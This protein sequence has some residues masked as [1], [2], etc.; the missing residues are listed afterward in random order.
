MRSNINV[1][2]RKIARGLIIKHGFN[3]LNDYLY[4]AA[5][6]AEIEVSE[7]VQAVKY[8]QYSPQQIRFRAVLKKQ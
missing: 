5:A 8:F 7:L 2:A 1:E 3:I 6:T 4:F